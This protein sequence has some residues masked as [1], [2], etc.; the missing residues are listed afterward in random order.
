MSA[1]KEEGGREKVVKIHVNKDKTDSQGNGAPEGEEKHELIEEKL[2][3]NMSEEELIQKLE[4][5]RDKSEKN[6]NQYLRAQADIENIIKRNKKDKEEWIKY[7]NEKLIKELLPVIDNL[8]KAISH[9]NDEN[10]LP[11]LREGVELTL[12]GLKDTLEK[13]GLEQIVSL[14]KPFDPNFHH[15]ISEQEDQN[16]EAGVIINEFQKGYILNQRLIR[17][18]MVVISK[19]KPNN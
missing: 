16:T 17:P 5:F 2:L 1:K 11:A 15:A 4:E 18:A 8:E 9:S 7:S 14:G 13:S 12:K 3:E 6:Y 19:G 10:S